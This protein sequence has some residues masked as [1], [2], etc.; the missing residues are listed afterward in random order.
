MSYFTP[1]FHF[2][3]SISHNRPMWPV[4]PV[5][6][7][8]HHKLILNTQWCQCSSY[9]ISCACENACVN[10]ITHG[11]HA[12]QW[13][14]M[15]DMYPQ[16][17]QGEWYNSVVRLSVMSASEGNS[18]SVQCNQKVHNT[19]SPINNK[20][21]T[22]PQTCCW[23]HDIRSFT[24]AWLQAWCKLCRRFTFMVIRHRLSVFLPIQ[25]YI[26]FTAKL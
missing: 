1:V 9:W 7:G 16:Q 17:L 12:L 24:A 20:P 19:R 15:F 13:K 2:Q 11:V 6:L 23:G 5:L 8:V 21:I 26:N 4:F 22:V 18:I 10:L 25:D 14:E 3:L